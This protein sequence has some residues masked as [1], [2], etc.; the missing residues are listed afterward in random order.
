MDNTDK[1]AKFLQAMSMLESS[2]GKNLKH[3][4]IKHGIHAGDAATGQYGLMPN[5]IDEMKRRAKLAGEEI[6]EG[7]EQVANK[8]YEHISAKTDDPV[9]QAH[10]WQHGHNMDP[11]DLTED[12]LSKSERAT[13]FRGLQ[14]KLGIKA[15]KVKSVVKQGKPEMVPESIE[16]DLSTPTLAAPIEPV[17]EPKP[18]VLQAST[19][20]PV[21]PTSMKI[22]E[23]SQVNPYNYKFKDFDTIT[24]RTDASRIKSPEE[25][26]ARLKG[27]V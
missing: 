25:L 5:T 9:K 8:L 13:R 24:A 1:K 11:D 4:T 17:I 27:R 14:G 16:P 15:P 2:G 21:M 20:E 23:P 7:E 12:V 26:K 18:S 10:M 22:P 19:P 3:K 6:P